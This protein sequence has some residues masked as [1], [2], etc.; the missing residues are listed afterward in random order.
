VLQF[1]SSTHVTHL[2]VPGLQI[3]VEPGHSELFVQSVVQVC[4]TE[5]QIGAVPGQSAEVVQ[6][7]QLFVLVSHLS[8]GAT[9]WVVSVAE[10]STQMPLLQTGAAFVQFWFVVHPM[11]HLWLGTSHLPLAPL[12]SGSEL[13]STQ[14]SF[15]AS[16]TGKAEVQAVVFVV[17][18]WTHWP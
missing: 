12:Q 3:G 5:L 2:P 1:A 4:V 8:F 14:T 6:P 15:T 11:V 17:R 16:H 9:Q 13:H 7:T 10:H 18:H